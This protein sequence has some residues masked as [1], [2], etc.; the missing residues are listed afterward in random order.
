MKLFIGSCIKNPAYGRHQISRPMLIEAPKQKKTYNDFS[1]SLGDLVKRG[2]A[3]VH[4]TAENWSTFLYIEL[5]WTSF[6]CSALHWKFF[7]ICSFNAQHFNSLDCIELHCIANYWFIVHCNVLDC[8]P[9]A[10]L[11]S[12]ALHLTAFHY[13]MRTNLHQSALGRFCPSLQNILLVTCKNTATNK[14]IFIN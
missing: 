11:H 6:L 9:P 8:I 14:K 1:S 7:F 5:H 4:S 12:T 13:N 2:I 10:T 3:A